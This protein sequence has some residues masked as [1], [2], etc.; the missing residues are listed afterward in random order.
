MYGFK[1]RHAQGKPVQNLADGAMSAMHVSASVTGSG[2]QN[3]SFSQTFGT[4]T[5]TNHN[6]SY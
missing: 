6:Y 3:D 1:P 5:S 4:N 2:S